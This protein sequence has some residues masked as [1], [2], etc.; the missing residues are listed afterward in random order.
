MIK[1][2]ASDLDGTL[3]NQNRTVSDTAIHQIRRLTEEK[4]IVFVSASGRQLGNMQKLFSPISGMIDYICEN[5]CFSFINHQISNLTLMEPATA[6]KL[7][8]AIL[9]YPGNEVLVSGISTSYV[10]SQNTQFVRYMENHVGN[11]VTPVNDILHTPEDYFKISFYN[12]KGVDSQVEYWKNIFGADL[13]VVTGGNCW[14]DMMPKQVNKQYGL[15]PVLE[16]YQ[17]KPE[18]CIMIGDNRNDI[19][20]LDYVGYPVA[21]DNA[22]PD[23]YQR[24]RRHTA[25]VE[26]ILD[27]VLNGSFC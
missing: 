1:L 4:G 7:I 3:L 27:Q 14:L 22:V 12:E 18:E 17:I 9:T 24:Y 23:V 10:R 15:L 11:H 16:Y 21:M 6:E 20:I 5:G 8:S 13:N 2:I 19:E 26:K 25:S